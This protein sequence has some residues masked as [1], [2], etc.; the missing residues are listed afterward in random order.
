VLELDGERGDSRFILV[1]AL[2]RDRVI[3]LRP[4]SVSLLRWIDCIVLS[5]VTGVPVAS[6]Y[7]DREGCGAITI[8]VGSK[9]GILN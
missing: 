9:E 3:T 4:V 8:L 5:L 6:L 7:I 2:D 1:R